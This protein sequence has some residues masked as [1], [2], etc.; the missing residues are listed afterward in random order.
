MNSFEGPIIGAEALFQ[1]TEALFLDIAMKKELLEGDKI[2][3]LITKI[4]QID[5]SAFIW[6]LFHSNSEVKLDMLRF[7]FRDDLVYKCP[8]LRSSIDNIMRYY[9][10]TGDKNAVSVIEDSRKRIE[11][12]FFYRLGRRCDNI[13]IGVFLGKM[14]EENLRSILSGILSID[15]PCTLLERRNTFDFLVEQGISREIIKNQ[16]DVFESEL[17]FNHLMATQEDRYLLSQIQQKLREMPVPA[18]GEVADGF[19][20]L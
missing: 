5:V 1:E 11:I 10:L 3:H 19:D 7:F 20:L 6:I 12:G 18:V 9:E 8:I 4:R 15:S 13:S 17:N 16:S 2:Q 14:S